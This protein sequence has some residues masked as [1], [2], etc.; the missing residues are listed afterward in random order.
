MSSLSFINHTESSIG[1]PTGMYSLEINFRCFFLQWS[2]TSFMMA[3]TNSSLSGCYIAWWKYIVSLSIFSKYARGSSMYYLLDYSS[4]AMVLLKLSSSSTYFIY[5][6]LAS[7]YH[8]S[9]DRLIWDRSLVDILRLISWSLLF[10]LT[11]FLWCCIF[12]RG[13]I[14]LV[15]CYQWSALLRLV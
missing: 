4:S 10:L 8:I 1:S 7:C 14:V 3:Q 15:F 9:I 5:Q 13:F 12:I 2:F 11:W 6:A